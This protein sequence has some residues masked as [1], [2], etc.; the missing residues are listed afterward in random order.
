VAAYVVDASVVVQGLIRDT[1]TPHVRALFGSLMLNTLYI[2]EFCLL[3]C[4][5]VLW[6]QV[7]F[8]NMP[9]ADAEQLINNLLALPLRIVP[10]SRLRFD[11]YRAGSAI[12]VSSH[13]CGSV[14]DARG[15]A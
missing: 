11:L 3:E 10:V 13:Q 14:A 8:H 4:V 5:N 1:Y 15:V 6:K 12:Q 2:P 9:S 7:R